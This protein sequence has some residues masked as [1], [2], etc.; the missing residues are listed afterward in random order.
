MKW[1]KFIFYFLFGLYVLACAI[2]YFLQERF[3]F[4]PDKLPQNHTYRMGEEIKLEVDDGISLSCWWMKAR[5]SKG[6]ILY[7]HGNKG[8]IRRCIY[9]AEGMLGNDYD[10]LMPDY[11]GYG[12]S[13]GKVYSEKQLFQDVQVAYDYLKERYSEDQIVVV[14]YSL[15]SGMASYLA[16]NNRPQQLFLLAP[17]YS[18]TDIK[19]QFLWF[20][21][22]FLLKYQL[23]TH[24]RIPK[25]KCPIHIFHGTNDHVIPYH[26]ATRLKELAPD[27]I[28]LNT[29]NGGSHRGVIFSNLF[30]RT[31][32]DKLR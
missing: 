2:L 21:P 29:I 5:R 8:S 22:D 1:L 19:D 18:I 4:L 11:R 30:K 16:A 7:L 10:I 23:A 17:Y 27:Q 24:Q 12:K 6:V 26:S 32:A 13:G 20:T 15:G 3:I 25:I 14:G 9:Q 28:E 31:I